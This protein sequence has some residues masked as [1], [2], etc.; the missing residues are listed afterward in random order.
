[1]YSN[2]YYKKFRSTWKYLQVLFTNGAAKA[3]M[4]PNAEADPA[5]TFLTMVGKSSVVNR[6]RMKKADVMQNFPNSDITVPNHQKSEK[7]SKNK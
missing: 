6:V 2:K 1:M 3:P 5:P 7:K 4:R